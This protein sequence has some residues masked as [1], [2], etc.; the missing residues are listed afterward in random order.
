MAIKRKG[1]VKMGRP[2]SPPHELRK[3]VVAIKLNDEEMGLLLARCDAA[4]LP[5]GA[6]ARRLVAAAL[7]RKVPTS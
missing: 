2:P 5:P 1:R 6:I 7:R 3:H 4:G